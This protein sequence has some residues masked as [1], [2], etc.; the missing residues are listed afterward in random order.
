MIGEGP[1]PLILGL[2]LLT[3]LAVG[4]FLGMLVVR[5]PE[6]M[7]VLGR[8][9]CPGCHE[10]LAPLDL[11]PLVSW[12][13]TR[14]KCRYCGGRISWF[15]PAVELAAALI[16]LWGAVVVP[17][18]VVIQTCLLGWTLL[19]LAVID[20]RTMTL[21]DVL[22]L[23]LAVAGLLAIG[24]YDQ[25]SLLEHA[26]A[27]GAGFLVFACVAYL[28]KRVRGKHGLGLGDAKLFAAGGA[29]LGLAGLWSVLLIG[30][31]SALVWAGL[32]AWRCGRLDT[33]SRL[34]FGP[35]LCLGIWLVWLYGPLQF[36]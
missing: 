35:F 3:G 1:E 31:F 25:S 7:S 36:G 27:A 29:W 14:R 34:P 4:S 18:E 21:P 13:V 24:L 2:L 17:S 15:Y 30:T 9:R 16:A 5:L 33:M 26:A 6:R 8:S 32:L 11:I 19:V 22:T 10:K 28:Y 20:W 23:P 12:L